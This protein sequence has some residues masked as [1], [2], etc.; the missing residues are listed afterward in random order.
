M[1]HLVDLYLLPG[2]VNGLDKMNL[3]EIALNDFYFFEGQKFGSFQSFNHMLPGA[4][5]ANHVISRTRARG[6][7]FLAGVLGAARG[8]VAS[9]LDRAFQG[10]VP[11]A[12]IMED[13]PYAGNTVMAPE[14]DT[15]GKL[16]VRFQYRIS[17]HD[18]KRLELFRRHLGSMLK[19]SGYQRI[20]DAENNESLTHACGTCRFGDDPSTSVLDP[21]NK[22][23]DLK[24]LYVVDASFLPSSTGMN[25]SLTLAANA[26]RV[27]SS[28]LK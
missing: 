15:S 9:V 4:F 27:G 21:V 25:P 1:R 10:K 19:P 28:L 17:D 22:T 6:H 12:S 13:L 18:R 11:Y 16:R 5:A 2:K 20:R 14:R 8:A 24:N 23:H 26:L 3:K 7:D